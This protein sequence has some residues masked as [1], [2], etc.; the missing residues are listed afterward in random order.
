MNEEENNAIYTDFD[1]D[2][3]TDTSKDNSHWT[4][5]PLYDVIDEDDPNKK[6]VSTNTHVKNV[7][8]L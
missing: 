3:I 5:E 4:C 1:I 2:T 7:A 6:K 8:K